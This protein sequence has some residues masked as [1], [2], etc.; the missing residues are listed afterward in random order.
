MGEGRLWVMWRDGRVG[1][2]V[3]AGGVEGEDA[4]G[5]G[6]RLA[7]EVRG[8]GGGGEEEMAREEGG[9]EGAEEAMMIEGEGEEGREVE[10]IRGGKWGQR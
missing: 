8:N 6:G 2:K 4:D 1:W 10:R 3:E 5:D 7:K 9:P